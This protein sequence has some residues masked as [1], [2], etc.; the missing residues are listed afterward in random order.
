MA[1]TPERHRGG[2]LGRHPSSRPVSSSWS[3]TTPHP[4]APR[5]QEEG[6][7]RAKN[8]CA[9]CARP[10]EEGQ[11]QASQARSNPW[12]PRIVLAKIILTCRGP[13]TRT[14]LGPAYHSRRLRDPYAE[15]I[16]IRSKRGLRTRNHHVRTLTNKGRA[17]APASTIRTDQQDLGRDT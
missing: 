12:V 15:G 11:G 4:E 9:P 16:R 14:T 3:E 6:G 13:G 8:D 5:A 1:S 2:R 10:L 17:S 7:S